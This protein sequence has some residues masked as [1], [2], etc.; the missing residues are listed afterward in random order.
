M[1]ALHRPRA[2]VQ[3]RADDAS[4]REAANQTLSEGRAEAVAGALKAKGVDEARIAARGYGAARPIAAN[5]NDEGKARNR[6]IE[7]IVRP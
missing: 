3:R 6:R 4:G 1:R 5:D 2:Y 7:V